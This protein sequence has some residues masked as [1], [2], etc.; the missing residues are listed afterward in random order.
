MDCVIIDHEDS[1]EEEYSGNVKKN[2]YK[3]C[4]IKDVH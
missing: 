2:N 3:I 1:D 4:T